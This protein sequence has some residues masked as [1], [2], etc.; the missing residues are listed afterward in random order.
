ATVDERTATKPAAA[1][2]I[3]G[4]PVPKVNG[5]D[6]VD[7][8]HRYTSDLQRDGML[9]GK[10]VRPPAYGATLTAADTSAAQ[11]MAGV[12]VIRDGNFLG[13]AAPSAAIAAAAAAAIKAEWT[14]GSRASARTLFTDLK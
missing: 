6:F 8:K 4:T 13:V 11:K 7:G 12:T 2:T 1:W 9:H 5:R 14:P 3:A 10:V